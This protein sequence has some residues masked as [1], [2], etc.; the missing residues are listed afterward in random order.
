MA[1]SYTNDRV[2]EVG[3]RHCQGR[4]GGGAGGG[5]W[6]LRHYQGDKTGLDKQDLDPRVIS[7]NH[8]LG[9]MTSNVKSQIKNANVLDGCAH[10]WSPD[11]AADFKNTSY[12]PFQQPKSVGL[13]SE[14]RLNYLK[15]MGAILPTYRGRS[16]KC[17]GA[18]FRSKSSN[19]TSSTSRS[20]KR[21]LL[22][23]LNNLSSTMSNEL[24][25]ATSH[26][27]ASNNQLEMA[28][29]PMS[30]GSLASNMYRSHNS[31]RDPCTARDSQLSTSRGSVMSGMTGMTGMTTGRGSQASGMVTGRDSQ[32]SGMQT[33]RSGAS[34]TLTGRSRISRASS[35]RTL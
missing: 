25:Q 24:A 31:A 4:V 22:H 27:R 33:G 28:A 11:C 16:G 19:G 8:V 3:M 29:R 30:R 13:I 7:L 20:K 10:K 26:M 9:N 18:T 6:R 15:C 21:V 17:P 35:R 2:S 12:N 34:G 5:A 1:A 23:Q 32:A 14:G